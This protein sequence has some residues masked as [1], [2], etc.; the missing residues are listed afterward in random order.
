MRRLLSLIILV[1]LLALS[2]DNTTN[3]HVIVDAEVHCFT[4][5]SLIKDLKEKYHEDP[6]FAGE[7]G[8]EAQTSTVVF[9]NQETGSYTIITTDQKI[10][11]ILDVGDSARY[12][13]PKAL[14][15]K[16]M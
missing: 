16:M 12:R 13:L 10:A 7:S 6:V 4:Y 9:I 15:S 8:F 14:H 5:K 1:P 3:G 11:C 2:K